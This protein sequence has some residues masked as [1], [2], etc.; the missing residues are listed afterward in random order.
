MKKKPRKQRNIVVLG[1]LLNC[2][3]GK[4]RDKRVRRPND[5]RAKV[6]EES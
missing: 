3:G 2:K 1:M 6:Q 4:M 5:K